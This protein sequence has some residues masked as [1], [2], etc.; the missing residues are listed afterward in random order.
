VETKP[1]TRFSDPYAV[2][3]DEVRRPVK[4]EIMIVKTQGN[5]EIIGFLLVVQNIEQRP[6][7]RSLSLQT[8]LK[9]TKKEEYY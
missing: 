8:Y 5:P 6:V 1:V 2:I 3:A 4:L 7:I 9:D